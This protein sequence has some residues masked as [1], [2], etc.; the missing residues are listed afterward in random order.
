[1][2]RETSSTD[3][4]PRRAIGRSVRA[5][6]RARTLNR[7]PMIVLGSV[8][9]GL[10]VGALLLRLAGHDPVASYAAMVR[11]AVGSRFAIGETLVRAAP[12]AAIGVGVSIAL[13][14]GVFTIGSEGQLVMGAVGATLAALWLREGPPFL[15]ISG[16]FVAA[17]VFGA[18]W[19]SLPAVLRARFE[20]NE[21]LSTLLFNYFAAYLLGY[22]LRE[23]LKPPSSPIS[24]SE[25]LP[26]AALLPS[27]LPGTRLHVGVLVAI[28]AAGAFALWVRS[29][30]GF[31]VDLFGQNSTLA[32]HVGVSPTWTIVGVMLVAGLLSGVAGWSQVAGLHRRLYVEVASG[33]GYLG[34]LVAVLGGLRPLGVIAASLLMAAL[35]AGG[36]FMEQTAHIP[37]TLSDVVQALILLSFAARLGPRL[38]RPRAS[39]GAEIAAEESAVAG[40]PTRGT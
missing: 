19:A 30:P 7:G 33:V 39:A 25:V 35:Q 24:Q 13:R 27:L 16:A 37:A 9:L 23:P 10:A 12:L 14:A 6:A 22:L 31:R 36:V 2:T 34:V 29:V 38:W 32:R 11:G 40:A 15:T 3:A 5:I 1:M 17:A 21:I 18:L 20:V 4:L 26:P 8:A 28:A